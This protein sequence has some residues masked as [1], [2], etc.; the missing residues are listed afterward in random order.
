MKGA[1][2]NDD[3]DAGQDERLVA[4]AR[5]GDE[6]AFG[7]M[8]RRHQQRVV[9]LAWRYLHDEEAAL[10][11]AQEV[12]LA[13]HLK[14]PTWDREGSLVSWLGRVA[15]NKA[16][17]R[18]RKRSSVRRAERASGN[19]RPA[20]EEPPPGV[21][22][23]GG[24]A[25]ETARVRAAVRRLSERQKAVVDMHFFERIPIAE[26]GRILGMTANN[27]RVTLYKSLKLLRRMLRK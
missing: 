11:V 16:I 13:L 20:A 19:T 18:R 6:S 17:E 2:P 9:H 4:R 23:P 26:V 7:E 27:V 24:D 15:A 21:A 25:S 12:F 22:G 1:A 3:G 14:L 8:V 5:Q 10:D